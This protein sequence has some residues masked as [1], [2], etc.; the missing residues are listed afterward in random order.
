MV[1]QGQPGCTS[2][3]L[4]G[5]C[6]VPR[7]ARRQTRR[8]RENVEGASTKNH[9]T[10]RC[11]S[12]CPVSQRRLRPTSD[13][14][15]HRTVRCAPDSVRCAKGT[16]GPMVG[17]ARKGRRSGTGQALF[18]SSGAPDCLV[19]HPTEGKNNLPNG[20]PTAPSY[21]GAIK[22]TPRR[23]EHKN[24]AFTKH[25]KTPRLRNHAI[26]SSCLR[27]EHFLSCKLPAP[28]LC[29]HV[30]TCVHVIAAILVLCVFLS[31]P[32][33]FAL[34]CDQRCKCERLHLVEI[35]HKQ[36][37]T[38]RKKPWYSSGSLDHLKGVESNP[39]PLGRHNVEVGKCYT[40]PNHGIKHRV[41]CV[42]FSL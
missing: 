4:I 14:W 6:P 1:G 24:Q 22:E 17:F 11:A 13:T 16:K 7:L 10:V 3:R 41:S 38:M 21:L 40:W 26:G 20:P 33:S 9:W 32:Y 12:D 2:L 29:A 25:S 35:P 42:A 5:Q 8:S 27:F 36:K 19:S 23:M 15:S 28:C 37:T 18:M 31:L 39:R 30:L 34:C